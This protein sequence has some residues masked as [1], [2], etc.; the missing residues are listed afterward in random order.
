MGLK[1]GPNN[2]YSPEGVLLKKLQYR[3]DLLVG[4]AFYYDAYGNIEY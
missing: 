2:Y 4:P 1:E 3:N